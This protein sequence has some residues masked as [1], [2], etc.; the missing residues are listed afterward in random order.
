MVEQDKEVAEDLRTMNLLKDISNITACVQY[1][2][3]C[4]SL[5]PDGRVPVLDLKVSIEDGKIVHD[6]YEKPCASKYVIP[7]SSAHSPPGR[8]WGCVDSGT[9]PVAWTGK[10]AVQ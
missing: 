3:D 10:G 4:P 2:V 7:F 9:I 6:F 8:G 1:T 5:Q